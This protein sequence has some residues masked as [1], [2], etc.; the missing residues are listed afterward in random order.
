VP[1]LPDIEGL[2]APVAHACIPLRLGGSMKGVLNVAA[3][4]GEQFSEYELHFLETLGHQVGLAVERARHRE[5]ERLR[6]QEARALAA[7]SRAVGGS[8]GVAA[9]LKAVGDTAR[10]VLVA[11]RASILLDSDPRRL[12]VAHLSGLP[13]PE[14]VERQTLDLVA[15]ESRL[16]LRALTE[17]R[18]LFIEDWRTDS[19]V[20]RELAE[21][22]GAASGV[23]A[24]L[25][26]RERT[27]GLLV[28]TCT[29]PRRWTEEQ[30]ALAEAF[31]SQASVAL[32]NAQLYEDARRAYQELKEAQDRILQS[33]KM[34]VLSTFASGLAHEVRN[35]LNSSRCRCPCWNGASPAWRPASAGRC[36]SWQTPSGRRSSA[37]TASWAISC[38]SHAATGARSTIQPAWTSWWTRLCAS[39]GRRRPPRA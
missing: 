27:F 10:K 33:E 21:R 37:W 19:R 15:N 8:L 32:D 34:A 25:V 9:V 7:I 3:R 12:R 36:A 22:W 24:P 11:D 28:L 13:H 23:V 17:R 5:A 14:L 2:D 4:P 6:D 31:A 29:A 16:Q 38:S 1:T 35:P 18:A 20:N 39:C 30:V 26:A